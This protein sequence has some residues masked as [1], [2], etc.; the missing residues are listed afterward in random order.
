MFDFGAMGNKG[1]VATVVG[2]EDGF[3]GEGKFVE[4]DWWCVFGAG[5]RIWGRRRE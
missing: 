3:C 4:V 2:E 1:R 5:C